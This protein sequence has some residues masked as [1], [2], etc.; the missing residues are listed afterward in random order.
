MIAIYAIGALV[1][2]AWGAALGTV[3]VVCLGIRREEKYS[4]LTVNSPGRAAGG[5][6]TIMAVSSRRPGM[7]YQ[8]RAQRED[9]LAA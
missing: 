4:S 1:L 9:D 3:I 7:A 8:I 6:R 2:I 5:V